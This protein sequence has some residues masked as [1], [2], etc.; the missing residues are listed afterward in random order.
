MIVP[1][2][3][4]MIETSNHDEGGSD[5]VFERTLSLP[6]GFSAPYSAMPDVRVP[7]LERLSTITAHR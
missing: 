6:G 1:L 3:S 7:S 4:L 2:Q 5:C